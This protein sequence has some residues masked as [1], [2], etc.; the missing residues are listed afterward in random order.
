MSKEISHKSIVTFHKDIAKGNKHINGFYRFNWNEI[1]GQFRSGVPTPAL[2]L[3]SYSSNLSDNQNQTTTFNNRKI[4][5][6]I[7]DF[8]GVPDD[9][10]KQEDVLDNLEKIGLQIIAYLKTKSN[11]KKSWLFG[12]F[13]ISSVEMEKVGPIFDNMYGWNI[14][15]NLR[16]HEPMCMD[17]AD[18]DFSFLE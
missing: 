12:K 15:Y 10:E 13:D 1:N 3:E 5:F 7:L 18:W 6:L 11:N 17:S 14:L 8:A 9:Y 16:N 2:L 4:S